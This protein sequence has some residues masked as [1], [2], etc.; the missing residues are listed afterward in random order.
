MDERGSPY[1]EIPYVGAVIPNTSPQ[2]LALCALWHRGPHPPEERYHVS[3]LGCGDGSNLLPLAFYH[4]ECTFVGI[5]SSREAIDRAREGVRQVGLSNVRFVVA[6]VR[7]LEPAGLEPSDYI[8]AHGLYSWVPDDAREAILRFCRHNLSPSG[9]AYV[10][11][12]AEPGWAIRRV[13]RETLL[14]APS[15]REA[16]EQQRAARAIRVATELLKDLPSRDY[17]H[18]ALLVEELERVRNAEP[19]YVAHEYLAEFNEGFWLGD[20][21]ERARRNDLAYVADAQFCRWEGQVPAALQ[22]RLAKRTLDVVAQEEAADVLCNR[23][24]H[25]SILCRADAPAATTSRSELLKRAHVA[26]P[27]A[28]QS[29]PFDL[30]HRAAE[31]FHGPR[32]AEGPEV[33]LDAAITKAAVVLLAQEWPRGARF[34]ELFERATKLLVEN[35]VDATNDARSQLSADLVSLFE[36]GQLDLRLA[37]PAFPAEVTDYP[38]AHALARFEAERRETLTTPFHSSLPVGQA[39]RALLRTTDGSRPLE[40]LQATHGKPLTQ[41]VLALVARFGFGLM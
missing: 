30:S 24:F 29:D 21:V 8:L 32:G 13:V 20:F 1:D 7:D 2:H 25:A 38:Q 36:A 23:S 37:E 12:N 14:R 19:F 17:A 10:S 3:E 31:R 34:G 18:A 5:D 40:E 26:T 39:E 22:A 15:V 11:Y 35:E 9:L 41:N 28:A 33:M 16:S 4:R 27:L 6:D